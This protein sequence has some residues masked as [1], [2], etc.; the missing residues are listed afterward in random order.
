MDQPVNYGQ[1]GFWRRLAAN[2]IDGFF[3]YAAASLLLALAALLHFRIP[4]ELLFIIVGATYS[5]AFVART[6]R[7]LGKALLQLRI[8]P[9]GAPSLGL[10]HVLL[11][12]L[13]GKWGLTVVLPM[14]LGRLICGRAWL[15][16]IC[17]LLL[18]LPV[19]LLLVLYTGIAKRSWY[20]QL[21]GTIVQREPVPR[22]EQTLAFVALVA[23]GVVALGTAVGEYAA[24]GRLPC[25]LA[26][27][28]SSRSTRPYTAFLKQNHPAPV[29]YV[30]GLFDRYD[31]VVLCERDH[32]EAT[33][34][35][36]IFDVVRDRR[37]VERVGRIFTEVGQVGMQ[38]YLDDFMATDGLSAEEVNRRTLQIQRNMGVWPRWTKT[39]FHTYLTRLYY[40]N[41]TLP[42][43]QRIRH[44]FTDAP[45]DWPNFTYGRYQAYLKQAVSHRDEIMAQ[46]VVN[47]MRRLAASGKIAPKCLVVMNYRHAFDLTARNPDRKRMNAFEFIKDA[48]GNRA[49]NVLI[50]TRVLGT[51]P[52]AQGLWDAAFEKLG[53][54]P[55]GF[56]LAGSPFGQ[57]PFDLFPFPYSKGGLATPIQEFRYAD[58]FTGYVFTHP[59]QDQYQQEGIPGYYDGFA[60]EVL[61]RAALISPDY[62]R[63]QQA[64]IQWAKS[65]VLPV[66]TKHWDYTAESYVSFASLGIASI[67]LLIA[68]VAFLFPGRVEVRSAL[69]VV[70]KKAQARLWLIFVG[71][72]L[73]SV[74]VHEVGHCLPAWL[75]GYPAVPT[76]AK[77]YILAV[78][79]DRVQ[80]A[81]ALGG[82]LGTVLALICALCLYLRRPTATTSAI[83]FGT[84][85]TP[86]LYVLRF[87]I[88]G[89]GHDGTEF[90]N[91]QAALG[92]SYSG[93]ALDWFF[94]TACTAIGLLWLLKSR[95]RPGIRF[96]RKRA[97]GAVFGLLLLLG[98][99]MINN[100]VF[101]PIFRSK[102]PRPVQNSGEHLHP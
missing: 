57:D 31:V 33:Q 39:N 101:D 12:E 67:G 81:I 41:Q 6:R 92:L 28:Q 68:M 8:V 27:Y 3:I 38:E 37:F 48:Y 63:T 82:I 14:L 53:N 32:W 94:L 72:I 20:D 56:D 11:R 7:T 29:D 77:E 99:Q 66:T 18:V 16:T 21:A 5:V 61:R 73:V 75:C 54:Q 44:F 50:N 69:P 58:V 22:P 76:P 85:L 93:H 49:A 70:S 95:T 43:E 88:A 74:Y 87:L 17:D 40:F 60:P 52:I 4:L 13:A 98:L 102:V 1:A 35:D 10:R 59:T 46:S 24:R 83:L 79:S 19:T 26:V 23:A 45:I 96:L 34:W 71:S 9:Q 51:V 84:L 100:M 42:R 97:M 62:A 89:R 64:D 80:H 90:Q 36:F 78:V 47:E 25:R 91:A 65:H 55:A 30:L 15:P 86:V 2:W